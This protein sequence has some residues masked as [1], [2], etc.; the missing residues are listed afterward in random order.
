MLC[1]SVLWSSCLRRARVGKEGCILLPYRKVWQSHPSWLHRRLLTWLF[2]WASQNLISFRTD[3]QESQSHAW[4]SASIWHF[5]MAWTPLREQ[6]VVT[7]CLLEIRIKSS[8]TQRGW[9]CKHLSHLH[10]QLAVHTPPLSVAC[11]LCTVIFILF[12]VRIGSLPSPI[13]SFPGV[14]CVA[15]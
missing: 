12:H 8:E 14:A 7:W 15:E 9:C 10:D 11:F 13:S 4:L 2:L 1:C 3:L 5:S 6:T